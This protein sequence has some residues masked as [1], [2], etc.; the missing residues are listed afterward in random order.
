MCCLFNDGFIFD[1]EERYEAAY[2]AT[3]LLR[4]D[5][6]DLLGSSGLQWFADRSATGLQSVCNYC[7]L[8]CMVCKY[9]LSMIAKTTLQS[10]YLF[11]SSKLQLHFFF[12]KLLRQ[13]VVVKVSYQASI[14]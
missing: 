6:F 4:S 11:P 7:R 2:Q 9:A 12:S 10:L 1:I 3:K 14:D 8:V 13:S 5:K